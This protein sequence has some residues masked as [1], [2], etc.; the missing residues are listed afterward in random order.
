MTQ[1]N[2]TI[3]IIGIDWFRFWGE[4]FGV[5][6]CVRARCSRVTPMMTTAKLSV[7][8]FVWWIVWKLLDFCDLP[9][10]KVFCFHFTA[11]LFSSLSLAAPDRI[12]Y[13]GLKCEYCTKYGQS[14]AD[15]NAV[16]LETSDV[17]PVLCDFDLGKMNTNLP[18]RIDLLLASP[19][20]H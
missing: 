17:C 4:L 19:D 13:G 8:R 18:P 9:Q 16:Q 11:F 14:S 12:G 7:W 20:L 1:S 6:V 3:D 10:K 2:H 15:I 5:C